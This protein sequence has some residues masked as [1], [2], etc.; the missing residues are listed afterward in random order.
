MYKSFQNTLSV[1]PQFNSLALHHFYQNKKKKKSY[2]MTRSAANPDIFI[3]YICYLLT[4]KKQP[5]QFC[6]YLTLLFVLIQ[7]TI[8]SSLPTH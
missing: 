6:T 8:K 1:K 7:L 3:F 2:C 5:E 4:G